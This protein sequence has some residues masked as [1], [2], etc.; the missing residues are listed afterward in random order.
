M[1]GEKWRSK[2]AAE[3]R[4]LKAEECRLALEEERLVKQRNVEQRTLIFMNPSTMD[5]TAKKLGA[6]SWRD[7]DSNGDHSSGM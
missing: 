2:L 4:K 5:D 1:E 3:E 6:H 7:L